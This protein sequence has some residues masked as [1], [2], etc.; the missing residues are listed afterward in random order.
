MAVWFLHAI[1]LFLFCIRLLF[2][3]FMRPCAHGIRSRNNALLFRY[4]SLIPCALRAWNQQSKQC[5]SV[6]IL[7]PN[8]VRPCAHGIN[9]RN[10]VFLF[11]YYT[12]ISLLWQKNF[13]PY[14]YII[15]ILNII[16]GTDLLHTRIA[17][18]FPDADTNQGISFLNNI[19]N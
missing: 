9:S 11:R 14:F 8:S 18:V 17:S 4:Y 6:S 15:R 2:H 7:F 10:S 13:F 19:R 16:K 1:K 12:T 3:N 5:L